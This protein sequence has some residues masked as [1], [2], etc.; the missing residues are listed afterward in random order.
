MAERNERKPIPFTPLAER[1]LLEHSFPGNVRELRN[2]MEHAVIRD[3]DGRLD[4]DDLPPT[5]LAAGHLRL[6]PN[7]GETT[8]E[9]TPT[10]APSEEARAIIEALRI[11][12]GNVLRTA[13]HL[14]IDRRQFYRLLGRHRIDPAAYRK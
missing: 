10:E 2:A 14:G 3:H 6:I 9:W 13:Q 11:C 12:Q 8:V 7:G 4:I 1:M 5:L